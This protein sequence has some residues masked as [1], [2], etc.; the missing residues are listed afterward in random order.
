[1]NRVANESR[2][3]RLEDQ[4][5][6][7]T[8]QLARKIHAS[9]LKTFAI[10]ET[11][12]DAR[13][14]SWP[15]YD[16]SLSNNLQ[17]ATSLP[18]QTLRLR[19]CERLQSRLAPDGAWLV[20]DGFGAS[21]AAARLLP[22]KQLVAKQTPIR[23]GSKGPLDDFAGKMNADG[24]LSR[25]FVQILVGGDERHLCALLTNLR[26]DF[27]WLGLYAMRSDPAALTPVLLH[28]EQVFA[29]IGGS[30]EFGAEQSYLFKQWKS[31]GVEL[32]AAW[33]VAA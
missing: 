32:R 9:T 11:T 29:A 13:Q 21:D 31:A 26:R 19:F 6:D 23:R 14:L 16:P 2:S 12:P 30:E 1:M 24:N 27:A 3:D 18:N 33:R 28:C 20:I 8:S 15:V 17:A 4:I 5:D 7:L 10:V 22:V 25:E